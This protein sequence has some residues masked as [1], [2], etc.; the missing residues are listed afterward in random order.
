M[1][2]FAG[3]GPWLLA[4]AMLAAGCAQQRERSDPLTDLRNPRLGESRRVE[5]IARAWREAEAGNLDKLTVRDDLKTIAWGAAY[6]RS[7]R[8]AALRAVLNDTQY[9]ADTRNMV[10]LM[11]PRESDPEVVGLLSETTAQRGWVDV[12]PSLV[13]SLSRVWADVKD[14]ERP[15]YRAISRL[16]KERSVPLVVYDVFLNPPKEE[17]AFGMVP[18]E[19]LRAD[20]WDVLSRLDVDGRLRARLIREGDEV[21]GPVIDMRSALQDLRTLP[22]TGEELRWLTSLRDRGDSRKIAWWGQT[23]SAVA[24]LGPA[25]STKLELRHME[26]IRWAS[27]HRPEWLHASR[28]Q[29]LTELREQLHAR[30]VYRRSRAERDRIPPRPERL[31]D[32]EAHLSWADALSI[33]VIDEALKDPVVR[34]TL[35]AQ[36]AMDRDDTTAEYGGLLRGDADTRAGVTSPFSVVLYPPRPGT[37]LGDDQFVASTDMIAQSDHALAHYHFHVQTVRNS[38]YAGPSPNDLAYAARHGRNCLV[39]TSVRPGVLNA[40]YYQPDSIVIDLGEIREP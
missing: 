25:Q 6:P 2:P 24:S 20:A 34:R 31:A 39:F 3:G 4:A 30:P 7:M 32:S 8:M 12:T 18:T 9:E 29:L 10:R 28:E 5:A 37:R 35:F 13:R 11:L 26:P 1:R 21:P 15:E 22:L 36:A 33:L 23:S 16:Y 19:R 40:D 38:E 17:P 14:A 27:Q